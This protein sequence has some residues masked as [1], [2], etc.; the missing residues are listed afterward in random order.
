MDCAPD[1]CHRLAVF[2]KI[3]EMGP[4]DGLKY[5]DLQSPYDECRNYRM[6]NWSLVRYW[7]A[8]SVP[9]L[10]SMMGP[11]P[12]NPPRSQ[13]LGNPLIACELLAALDGDASDAVPPL[14][15]FLSKEFYVEDSVFS[16]I[17]TLTCIGVGSDQIVDYGINV[18]NGSYLGPYDLNYRKTSVCYMLGRLADPTD[19]RVIDKIKEYLDLTLQPRMPGTFGYSFRDSDAARA[20]LYMLG[21][22]QDEMLRAIVENGDGYALIRIGDERAIEALKEVLSHPVVDPLK[23]NVYLPLEELCLLGPR[24][25]VMEI[26][27]DRLKN[28]ETGQDYYLLDLISSFG[29]DAIDTLPYLLEI[30]RKRKAEESGLSDGV[31]RARLLPLETAII[32]VSEGTYW[33]VDD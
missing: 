20:A 32:R 30:Y 17:E 2:Y 15:Q 5:L 29:P 31:N 7:G 11:E 3:R 10:I 22:D 27:I 25:D 14:T 23:W 13:E 24:D 6:Y 4:V 33:Q 8:A 1:A 12:Y 26:I 9:G 16:P 19:Q 28:W 21:V 18:L